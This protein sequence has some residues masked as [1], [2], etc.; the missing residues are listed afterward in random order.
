M[1]NVVCRDETLRTKVKED[2]KAVFSTIHRHKMGE[3]INEVLFCMNMEVDAK[4]WSDAMEASAK[5]TYGKTGK[6]TAD[7]MV[8][9]SELLEKL[10]IK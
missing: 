9:L 8:D 4:T 5:R 10:R 7:N 2:L 1:L 3:D 6:D